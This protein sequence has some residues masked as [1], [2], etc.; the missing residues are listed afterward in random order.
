MRGGCSAAASAPVPGEWR[1]LVIF[2]VR[3][4][5]NLRISTVTP[6]A[7]DWPPAPGGMLIERDAFQVAKA[8]DRRHR[9]DRDAVRPR[10][11][12]CASPARV[13]D[14]G[15][16]QARMENIVYGYITPATLAALGETPALDRLYLLVGGRPVP[17]DE[18]R[19]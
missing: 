13:H 14:A 2:V 6:E 8:S 9:H 19:T 18:E 1:R 10:A 7:G 3:D 15:Q 16:A 5:R 12:S 4:F 17:V 11:D